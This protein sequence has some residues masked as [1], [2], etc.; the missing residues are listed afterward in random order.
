VKRFTA[1][2]LTENS[3]PVPEDTELWASFRC[4]AFLPRKLGSVFSQPVAFATGC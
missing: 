3:P 4:S 1:S 2:E